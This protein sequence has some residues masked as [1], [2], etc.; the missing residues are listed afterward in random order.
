MDNIKTVEDLIRAKNLTPEELELHRELIEEC[1]EN[2]K[3]INEYCNAARENLRKMYNTLDNVSK[4]AAEIHDAFERLVEETENL[5]LRLI[6]DE[7][8]HRE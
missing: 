2:E 3:K 1:R 4:K 7:K 8:F 5:S 6:P